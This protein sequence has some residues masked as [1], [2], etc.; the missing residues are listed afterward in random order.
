M[1]TTKPQLFVTSADGTGNRARLS[2]K[3]LLPCDVCG[4]VFDRP[5]LL[6][7]H[8]RTHTGNW[9]SYITSTNRSRQKF[10]INWWHY[11]TCYY[12]HINTL[13]ATVNS[14]H[15]QWTLTGAGADYGKDK[16]ET[17]LFKKPPGHLPHSLPV[18][19]NTSCSYTKTGRSSPHSVSPRTTPFHCDQTFDERSLDKD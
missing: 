14:A 7:R 11:N 6:K 13:T 5:S 18:S 2:Q 9:Q 10:C 15:S 17:L 4:K 19:C 8:M 1:G 12:T 16:H 3:S